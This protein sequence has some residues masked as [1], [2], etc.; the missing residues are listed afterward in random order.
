MRV[1]AIDADGTFEDGRHV[2]EVD[3]DAGVVERVMQVFEDL[4]GRE[5]LRPED[6][7]GLSQDQWHALVLVYPSMFTFE[8]S[9]AEDEIRSEFNFQVPD[10]SGC[11]GVVAG[12][13]SDH[14]WVYCLAESEQMYASAK[15]EAMAMCL[16]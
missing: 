5:D 10:L 9:Q 15:T 7:S 3:L 6:V 16:D 4:G 11:Y 14:S 13:L 8:V 12:M 2:C 1:F